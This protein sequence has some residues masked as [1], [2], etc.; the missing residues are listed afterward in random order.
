MTGITAETLAAIRQIGRE[1]NP[2]TIEQT[3]VAVTPVMRAVEPPAGLQ[4]TRDTAYGPAGERNLLDVYAAEGISGAPVL[5]FVHGGGFVAGDRSDGT[6]YDNVGH[7]A[8]REGFVAVVIT[9]RLAPMAHWPAGAEDVAAALAW[10][11]DH[12]A[13]H[14]GDPGRIVVVGHSAGGAHVSGAV[15]GHA[16]DLVDLAGVVLVSAIVDPASAQ[17][18]PMLH[19]YYGRDPRGQQQATA[20]PGVAGSPLPLLLAVAELDPPD[21]HHQA[22]VLATARLQA[23]GT[24]PEVLVVPGHNHLTEVFTLGL[25]EHAFGPR[26]ADFVRRVTGA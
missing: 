18:N 19:A 13:E 1:F 2:E 17:Q 8:V 14:G 10:A 21:F 3:R 7:W 26:L 9:Y 25:D 24:L 12:V 15:A 4:V 16:G 5:V 11:R 20:V 23:T 22:L 6:F